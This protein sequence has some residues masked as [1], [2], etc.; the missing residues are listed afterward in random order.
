M[1]TVSLL[2][3]LSL[4]LLVS[5][6]GMQARTP[7]L[8]GGQQ[9]SVSGLSVVF[10][11]GERLACIHERGERSSVAVPWGLPARTPALP[12]G[13][14]VQ[15]TSVVGRSTE[16]VL[17]FLVCF[18]LIFVVMFFAQL[19]PRRTRC[20]STSRPVEFG[21]MEPQGLHSA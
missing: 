11:E 1:G 9:L 3:H 13:L 4:T 5:V 7:A 6:W 19:G 18:R 2:P 21:G 12:G 20:K 10:G 16:E 14:A 8:P 15:K 17:I